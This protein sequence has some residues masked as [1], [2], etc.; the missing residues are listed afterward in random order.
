MIAKQQFGFSKAEI[1]NGLCEALVRNYIN[2]LG[3]GKKLDPPYV[4]QGGVAANKGIVAAFERELN[5]KVI[6]PD[7]YDVMGAIGA[8]VLAKES[9]ERTGEKT[10]FRGFECAELDF[11]PT[12]FICDGCDNS[13]EVIKIM[14][15]GKILAMWGDRCGKWTN[16]IT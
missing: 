6:V 11:V 2:N 14:M 7:N 4:F 10:K 16:S 15:D 3:R 12:S 13:C 8:A 1:I 9:I 5:H